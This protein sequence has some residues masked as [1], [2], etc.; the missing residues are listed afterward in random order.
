MTFCIFFYLGIK[1]R[2]STYRRGLTFYSRLKNAC[3]SHDFITREELAHIVIVIPP[4]F[5]E[6]PI[7]SPESERSV[8]WVLSVSQLSPENGE[9]IVLL[10]FVQINLEYFGGQLRLQFSIYNF[11]RC[12]YIFWRYVC[13]WIGLWFIFLQNN[14]LLNLN[15]W[16]KY[17]SN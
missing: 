14:R 7:P 11:P 4:H 3:M 16:H 1:Q 17:L 5:I 8:V 12:M 15:A 10:L 9:H 6:V 13:M 2:C